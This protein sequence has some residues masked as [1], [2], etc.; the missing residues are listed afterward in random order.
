M[1]DEHHHHILWARKEFDEMEIL[2]WGLLMGH[3]AL[4]SFLRARCAEIP[5]THHS[6]Y[7]AKEII[8]LMKLKFFFSF[9][10][11][12]V[13]LRLSIPYCWGSPFV[14]AILLR[15]FPRRTN[16]EW[17]FIRGYALSNDDRK[18]IK[19]LCAG[20]EAKNRW[21]KNFILTT[22]FSRLR[23]SFFAFALKIP[24]VAR[25]LCENIAKR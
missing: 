13:H 24:C 17:I 15:P 25:F 23:S 19:K 3:F 21:E 11:I 8:Y 4:F 9:A 12:S 20:T 16:I 10:R 22:G 18:I 7:P 2:K 1:T 14:F 6:M 5:F